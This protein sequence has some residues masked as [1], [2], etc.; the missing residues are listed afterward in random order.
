MKEMLA[1][2]ELL[3][4]QIAEY[5]RLQQTAKSQLKRD[6]YARV[7]SR[8]KAIAR[9]LEQAIACLPDFRPLRRP[10][11]QDEEK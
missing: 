1:H 4:V 3:R 11:R 7:I 8:Y 5:E 9:E 6:V 2:L 10:Q